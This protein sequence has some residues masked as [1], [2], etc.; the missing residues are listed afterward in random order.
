V[1]LVELILAFVDQKLSVT[2]I[3]LNKKKFFFFIPQGGGCRGTTLKEK[4]TL[5]QIMEIK[6]REKKVGKKRK[7]LPM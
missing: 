5:N 2:N 3:L 4:N 6:T 7:R 1:E